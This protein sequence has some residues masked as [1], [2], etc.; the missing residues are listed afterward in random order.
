MPDLTPKR[1]LVV[2]DVE[3]NREIFR[4]HL[5]ES[6]QHI[7]EAADGLAAL[8]LF[9]QQPYDAV[10]MDMEMPVLDGYDAIKA[11]RDWEREQRLPRTLILAV[12]SSDFP[13][14]E[15]RIME[16][17]ASAYLTKP[18]KQKALLT[19]FH[20]HRSVDMAAHPMANLLPKVFAY[21]GTM[22]DEIA[23]FDDPE[24]VSKGLHQ[25]R[26]MIAVYGFAGFAER[27][28]HIHVAAQQGKIPEKP[29]L[30]QLREELRAL[31]T[32]SSKT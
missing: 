8:A 9:K 5:K 20:L 3:L 13:E 28:K 10:L 25:L 29:V 22:L 2:D 23:G 30:D 7:D 12:T 21:A 4:A 24:A 6:F 17:G 26:G 15:Q 18:V 19:A 1:A 31:Q 11:M 16:A 14:D 32:A 27:L